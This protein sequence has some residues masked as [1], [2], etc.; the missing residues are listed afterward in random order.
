MALRKFTCER[1][2]LSTFADQALSVP[3]AWAQGEV[4]REHT[5][6]VAYWCPECRPPAT[7]DPLVRLRECE[8]ALKEIRVETNKT[9]QIAGDPKRLTMLLLD[10]VEATER[11][12]KGVGK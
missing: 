7:P 4:F 8:A 5:M 10:T 6:G 3:G 11:I 9:V 12:L 2:G 1:C